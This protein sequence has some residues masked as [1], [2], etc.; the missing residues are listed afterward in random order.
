MNDI[1][2]KEQAR[3]K[4]LVAHSRT[5][6]MQAL[7][8]KV[9]DTDTLHFSYLDFY[10][11]VAFSIAHPLMAFAMIRKLEEPSDI[12]YEAVNRLNLESVLGS[13]SVDDTAGC[14][15]YRTAHWLETE[16]SAE[17]LLEM[18]NRCM[19]EAARGYERLSSSV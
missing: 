15:F 10:V 9:A 17:R 12:D 5:I 14:Y 4:H 11:Q 13:H 7:D 18:L 2:P 19:D 16:L 6:F 8:V 1:A 3:R